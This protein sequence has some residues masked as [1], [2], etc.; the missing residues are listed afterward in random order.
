MGELRYP[1]A[2]LASRRAPRSVVTRLFRPNGKPTLGVAERAFL[3]EL[4]RMEVPLGIALAEYNDALVHDDVQAGV[5]SARRLLGI[6][7]L[8]KDGADRVI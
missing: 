8:L 2:P 5:R 4:R 1:D 7:A 6:A 3:R